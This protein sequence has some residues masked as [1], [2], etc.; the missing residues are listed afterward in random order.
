[1]SLIRKDELTYAEGIA[2]ENRFDATIPPHLLGPAPVYCTELDA[3]R[4]DLKIIERQLAS[5]TATLADARAEN[6][7]AMIIDSLAREANRLRSQWLDVADR[8][9]QLSE[10]QTKLAA[11]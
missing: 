10:A 2:L 11:E 7:H 4:N 8:I 5:A 6:S 1:M 9:D 3:H